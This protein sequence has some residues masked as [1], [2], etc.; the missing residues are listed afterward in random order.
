M[1]NNPTKGSIKGKD[2]S[3]YIRMIDEEQ[4]SESLPDVF[5]SLSTAF[6]YV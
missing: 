3:P 6:W 4:E 5:F 1:G 2:E